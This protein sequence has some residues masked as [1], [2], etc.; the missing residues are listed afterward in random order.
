MVVVV[1]VV[2]VVVLNPVK[3]V[4]TCNLTLGRRRQEDPWESQAVRSWLTQDLGTEVFLTISLLYS[5]SS[6]Q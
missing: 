1:V 3:M 5:A 2:A 6:G 4:H